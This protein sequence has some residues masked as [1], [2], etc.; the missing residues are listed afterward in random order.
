M[1]SAQHPRPGPL[2]GQSLR[3]PAPALWL[4]GERGVRVPWTTP[5]APRLAPGIHSGAGVSCSPVR[6]RGKEEGEAA[7]RALFWKGP[8][9][10]S[11]FWPAEPPQD[12]ARSQPLR[13]RAGGA[14][15]QINRKGR[16]PAPVF[17]SPS[18]A[19][20]AGWAGTCC[21]PWSHILSVTALWKRPSCPGQHGWAGAGH[22][23]PS[24]LLALWSRNGCCQ[25]PVPAWPGASP[26]VPLP[27]G[28]VM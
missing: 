10:P 9:G 20:S 18:Q 21:H 14:G 7:M 19:L 2:A 1:S 11:T 23:P 28:V 24:L 15:K 8:R 22:S 27:P 3:G 17:V 5:A 16:S 4:P 26:P 12:G 13:S 25:G 6:T